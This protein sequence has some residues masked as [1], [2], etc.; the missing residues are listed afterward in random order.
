MAS[1]AGVAF[2]VVP[3]G[4]FF[5]NPVE[6]E[7]ITRYSCDAIF[8]SLAARNNMAS[9]VTIMTEKRSIGTKS[10]TIRIDSG[11]GSG[12]LVLPRYGGSSTTKTAVLRSMT[13]VEGYGALALPEFKAKLEFVIVGSTS[14]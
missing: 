1:F 9:K 12:S 13:D 3:N 4:N 6:D 11:Y 7:G 5:P 2:S 10:V 8:L 14:V